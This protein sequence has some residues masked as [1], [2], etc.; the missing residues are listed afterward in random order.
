MLFFKVLDIT[1]PIVTLATKVAIKQAGASDYWEYGSVFVIDI[2]FTITKWMLEEYYSEN[3]NRQVRDGV[4][5]QRIEPGE[6]V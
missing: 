4:E 6:D 1:K 3:N 5:L 2:I